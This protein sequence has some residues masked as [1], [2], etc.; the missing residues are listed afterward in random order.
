MGLMDF[1]KGRAKDKITGVSTR[2]LKQVEGFDT[3]WLEKP[4][5]KDLVA[6]LMQIAKTDVDVTRINSRRYLKRLAYGTATVDN[7]HVKQ[8]LEA[9]GIEREMLE[10]DG[11]I[12]QAMHKLRDAA[13]VAN[14]RREARVDPEQV[15]A[16]L[17]VCALVFARFILERHPDYA[18][19]LPVLAPALADIA[20]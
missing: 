1:F 17:N 14:K 16:T 12:N 11:Y 3:A 8:I 9:T 4:Q 18:E 13:L 19:Q 5:F 20:D 2:K 15:Q 10:V 6:C 7:K